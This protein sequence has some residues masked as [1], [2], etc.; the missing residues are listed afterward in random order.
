MSNPIHFTHHHQ[1]INYSIIHKQHFIMLPFLEQIGAPLLIVSD[2]AR[3]PAR[4]ET[5]S[6]PPVRRRRDRDAWK[7]RS[8]SAGGERHHHHLDHCHGSSSSSSSSSPRPSYNR[9]D[10]SCSKFSPNAV[11]HHTNS[12]PSLKLLQIPRRQSS[13][14]RSTGTCSAPKQPVRRMNSLEFSSSNS[15]NMIQD[16]ARLLEQALLI[17]KDE[18]LSCEFWSSRSKTVEQTSRRCMEHPRCKLLL[19]L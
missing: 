12:A 17:T 11:S 18:C 9:W 10:T 13:F 14:R 8:S 2:N 4:S 5:L 6:A 19:T 1:H 16:T 15:N 7:R 3:L